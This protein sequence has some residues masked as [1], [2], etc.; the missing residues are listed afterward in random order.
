MPPNKQQ[1]PLLI[2]FLTLRRCIGFLGILLPAILLLGTLILADCENIQDSISHY[3]FTIMGDVFVGILSAVALFLILYKGYDKLDNIATNCAGVFAIGIALF[4]TTE[5]KDIEC[6]LFKFDNHLVHTIHYI[7]AALFFIT[8]A[9]ISY[10]LFTKTSGLPTNK[11]KERN[12]VYR[13]CGVVIIIAVIAIFI[14]HQAELMDKFPNFKPVFFLE[15]IAL[16]AFGISWIVKGEFIM[17][18]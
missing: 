11:K 16:I 2:S 18:D 17:K 4:P 8:T 3:Y 1:N 15:W 7:F 14:I 5:N 12:N 13:A 6:A 10:F 9:C